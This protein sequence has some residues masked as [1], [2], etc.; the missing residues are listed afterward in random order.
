MKQ[1]AIISIQSVI[2][3]EMAKDDQNFQK[4]IKNFNMKIDWNLMRIELNIFEVKLSKL[5]K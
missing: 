2:I 1:L 3:V 4:M 5:Q